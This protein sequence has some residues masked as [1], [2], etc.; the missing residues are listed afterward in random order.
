MKKSNCRLFF[1]FLLAAITS[2][3]QQQPCR[4]DSLQPILIDT[5]PPEL[6]YVQFPSIIKQHSEQS[7]DDIIAFAEKRRAYVI[8][9]Y[10]KDQ[11]FGK[12]II[13]ILR[14]YN[15]P[16]ELRLLVA[17]ES[18]YNPN[19]ISGA[20]A[21]GYWQFMDEPAREYGLTIVEK[22]DRE[23]AGT[24]KTK[25]QAGIKGKPVKKS[26]QRDDRKN[27]VRSTHAA[28]KYLR[29]RSRNLHNDWLL[30][31]A[32]YNCG[33]GNVWEAMKKS[34]KQNPSFWDIRHLLPSETRNYVTNFINL[35]VLIHNYQA[36]IKGNLVFE[37]ATASKEETVAASVPVSVEASDTK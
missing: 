19:A 14:K 17:L 22:E 31:V 8:R 9:T 36:Y 18:A 33:V 4:Q 11:R 20:G 29:D 2:S 16:A 32:S 30:I 1:L 34:G 25:M 24:N 23:A 21:V 6:L 28:A 10:T 13:P 27:L 26:P 35:S 12:K 15:V 7:I 3:A 37:I 5:L